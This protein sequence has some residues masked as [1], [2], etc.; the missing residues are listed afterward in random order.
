MQDEG[1]SLSESLGTEGSAGGCFS[2]GVLQGVPETGM[3][4]VGWAQLGPC[5]ANHQTLGGYL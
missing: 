5:P 2:S 3:W 4:R 1:L